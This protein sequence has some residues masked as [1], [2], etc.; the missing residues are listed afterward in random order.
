[1]DKLNKIVFGSASSIIIILLIAT[2]L[3]PDSSELI[4]QHVQS[5]LVTNGSWFYVLTVGIILI[6][7]IFLAMSEYGSIKL[8]AD[9]STPDYSLV[10]WLAMLFAA[11]MGIGLM[12]FGV[13][14]PLMHFLAPPTAEI[15]SLDAVREAMKITFF[16]WGLHA[17]AIYAIVALILAYYSYRQGLPLTLRSSLY[18]LIGDNIY[19][20]PG[21][22]VDTFAVVST[23]FGV[24]TSLGF[25]ASQINSG[26]HYLFGLEVS[27]INQVIIMAAIT[28]MAATS[29]ATGLD[30]GIKILSEINLAM[31]LMLMLLVFVLGSSV[32]LL[33]AYVQNIGAYVSDL[34][35]NT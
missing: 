1:L 16:H 26:L 4:F 3:N 2:A 14:E 23:V 21:H 28:I 7:V 24:A 5:V 12:F 17:W 11:G 32:F 15:Q 6:F 31:A 27:V 9:H 18:P 30:R 35:R 10:S 22:V 8:G 13:A 33:Q 20:W 19:R 25:G 29:V 34:V